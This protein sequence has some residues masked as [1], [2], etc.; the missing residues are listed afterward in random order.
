MEARHEAILATIDARVESIISASA[1]SE[2]IKHELSNVSGSIDVKEKL[3]EIK[4]RLLRVLT[5]NT[6]YEDFTN[7]LNE[8]ESHPFFNPK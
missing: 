3:N 7:K 2:E 8:L 6:Y 1:E 5:D 4:K